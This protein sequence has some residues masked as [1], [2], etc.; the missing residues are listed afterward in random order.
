[1]NI[2]TRLLAGVLGSAM[3]AGAALAAGGSDMS[4][5]TAAKQGDRAQVQSLL[6]GRT[7]QSVTGTEGTAALVWAITR[8]DPA[9][10]DMLLKA[11]ANAKAANEFG[12]T[13]VYA[14][15]AQSDPALTVKLLAAGADANT[16]LMSGETPLDR[17]STRLNSSHSSISYAVFCLKKK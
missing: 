1:M 13:P 10:V 4:L 17:K 16:P 14:A 11:G 9:M 5:V 12:A 8:N 15:A 6:T 7:K 2:R 3:F